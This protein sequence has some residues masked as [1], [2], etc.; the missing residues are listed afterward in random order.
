MISTC[1]KEDCN[2]IAKTKGFCAKHYFQVYWYTNK[3]PQ[4]KKDERKELK[5]WEKIHKSTGKHCNTC[6]QIKPLHEFY[7]KPAGQRG[8]SGGCKKCMHESRQEEN[9]YYHRLYEP[10]RIE[11]EIQIL[12]EAFN[13]YGNRCAGCGHTDLVALQ[14]HHRTNMHYRKASERGERNKLQVC[15]Q[16]AKKKSKIGGVILLCANCHSKFDRQDNTAIRGLLMDRV[17]K[18]LVTGDICIPQH[19]N[20]E[21]VNSDSKKKCSKCKQIKL[22]EFFDKKGKRRTSHCKECISA[23]RKSKEI[24]ETASVVM[25]YGNRCVGCGNTDISLL[26]FHHHDGVDGSANRKKSARKRQEV[27]RILQLGKKLDK[28]SLLCCN[29]HIKFDILDGTNKIGTLREKVMVYRKEQA[30]ARS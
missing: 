10:T 2:E 22:L 8:V 1:K 15:K 20:K 26:Q 17:E 16:I 21:I 18:Y 3:V 12:S 9:K 28:V 19:K 6:K 5:E 7:K 13:V 4:H 24:I 27:Q 14:F 25:I 23:Y 30:N 29:C 11:K